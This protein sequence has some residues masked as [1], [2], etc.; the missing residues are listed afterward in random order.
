MT[1]ADGTPDFS[2]AT[3]L[4]NLLHNKAAHSATMPNAAAKKTCNK[5]GI[6]L[7]RRRCLISATLLVGAIANIHKRKDQNL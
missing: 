7:Y 2:C 1:K 4:H 5:H 3:L 6:K